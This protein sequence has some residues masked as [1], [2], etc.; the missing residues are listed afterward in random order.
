MKNVDPAAEKASFFNF[1]ATW[2][3]FDRTS[4]R[5]E[6]SPPPG[7]GVKGWGGVGWLGWVGWVAGW[8]VAGWL[9]AGVWRLVAGVWRLVSG[10][11]RL[12]SG[13]GL[14]KD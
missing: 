2:E 4:S 3:D 11:W 7:A 1:G 8:L 6:H 10:V 5:S 9:A 12:A 14:G 13:G